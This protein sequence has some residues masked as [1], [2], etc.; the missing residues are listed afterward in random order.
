MEMI[1]KK[2]LVAASLLAAVLASVGTAS[3]QDS[4]DKQQPELRPWTLR[5][6]YWRASGDYAGWGVYSWKG[7]NQGA[8]KWPANWKFNGKDKFGSYY[9]VMLGEGASSI[10]F[11]VTDGKGNKNCQKDQKYQLPS[12][13]GQKGAEIWL[14]ENECTIHTSQ[15]KR[16]LID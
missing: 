2:G 4:G 1:S 6:H 15:P 13:L 8:P 12:D 5:V 7:P 3:A 10:E 9:D 16:S 11:L 14:R